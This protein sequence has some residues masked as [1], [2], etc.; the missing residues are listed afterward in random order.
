MRT[1]AEGVEDRIQL[2]TL[3]K[4]GC[5]LIQGYYFSRPLPVKELQT[6]LQHDF[7]VRGNY[8]AL[9]LPVGSSDSP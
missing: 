1:V 7:P 3:Q 6:L 8:A 5:H 4:M 9:N 2:E